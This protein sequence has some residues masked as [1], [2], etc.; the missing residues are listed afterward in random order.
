MVKHRDYA[1]DGL[2]GRDCWVK[3]LQVAVPNS[4]DVIFSGSFT[5]VAA[6]VLL[7][8]LQSSNL[9]SAIQQLENRIE[10]TR[11]AIAK[12]QERLGQE[13][14]TQQVDA[15]KRQI[16]TLQHERLDL[17]NRLGSYQTQQASE[18]ALK[19]LKKLVPEVLPIPPEHSTSARCPNRT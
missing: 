8:A 5:M 16:N 10:Q 17:G 14:Q 3:S 1:E 6:A 2:T 18:E 15:D 9:Q 13:K 19:K 7:I 12:L 11:A 4:G